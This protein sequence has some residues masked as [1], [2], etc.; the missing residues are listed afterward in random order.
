MDLIFFTT[1]ALLGVG[2]AMDACAVSMANGLRESKIKLKKILFISFM[3]GLF[4]G[5]MP[6]L[7]YLIGSQFIKY[8]EGFIPWLALAILGYLGISMILG[9]IKGE[10]DED[11]WEALT[12]KVIMVQTIATSIDALSVG[13]TIADYRNYCMWFNFC[14]LYCC[15]LYWK[16]IWR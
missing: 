8:I 7:G 6:L 15:S 4:Q 9:A 12:F 5:L 14:H 11:N 1:S 3:F 2:L 10:E 16:E 13:L